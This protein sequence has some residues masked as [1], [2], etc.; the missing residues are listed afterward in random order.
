[1]SYQWDGWGVKNREETKLENPEWK[2]MLSF[3]LEVS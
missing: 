1:L 2:L 3:H